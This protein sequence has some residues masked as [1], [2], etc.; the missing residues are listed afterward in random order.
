MKAP[1]ARLHVITA[2]ASDTALVLRRGPSAQVASL[3]W[4]RSTDRLEM[5]QWFKGRIYEHRADISPDGRHFVYFAGKGTHWWTAVS[6]APWLTALAFFPQ[7]DTWHGGGAF[8]DTGDLWLNGADAAGH[9][10]PD[11][12]RAASTDAFPHGTDGFHMGDMFAQTQTL[13]GWRHQEGRGYDAVLQKPLHAG[14]LLELRFVL[15]AP[16]RSLISHQYALVHPHRGLRVD[17]TDWEWADV[18]GERV[19]Y[20]SGGM[21]RAAIVQTEGALDQVRVIHDF[22]PMTFESRPSPYVGVGDKRG[23]Q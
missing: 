16:K 23:A 1:A 22:T 7:S 21:L 10:L 5:G 13:R 15:S 12:L 4:D 20:A 14:W 17:M 3:L 19:Q 9:P 2:T 8:S 6:R 11:G 18:W